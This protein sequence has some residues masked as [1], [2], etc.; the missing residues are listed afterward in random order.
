MSTSLASLQ[1]NITKWA[2]EVYPNRTVFGMLAKLVLEEIPEF[3]L[4]TKD[5]GEYA[6]IVIMIL[7]IASINGINVEEAVIKKMKINANREWVI[8]QETGMMKHTKG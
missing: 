3:L 7:D 6:D 1:N 4:D 2:D 8:N 5:E